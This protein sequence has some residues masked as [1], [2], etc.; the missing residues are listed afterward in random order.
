MS[1]NLNRRAFLKTAASA[2]TASALSAPGLKT[3]E[4]T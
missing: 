4:N 2:S 1:K 3:R